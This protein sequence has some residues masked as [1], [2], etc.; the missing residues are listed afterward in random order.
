MMIT[1]W[2]FI[3]FK[4]KDAAHPVNAYICKH[5]V[6]AHCEIKSPVCTWAAYGES[7]L[8]KDIRVLES[9]EVT[10]DSY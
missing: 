8:K 6:A 9:R 7:A 2:L 4:R 3:E 1:T 5:E 10:S